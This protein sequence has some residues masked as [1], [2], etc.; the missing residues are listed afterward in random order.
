METMLVLDKFRSG[1]HPSRKPGFYYSS[2]CPEHKSLLLR[3]MCPFVPEVGVG[4]SVRNISLA[5]EAAWLKPLMV[6]HRCAP[7]SRQPL[8]QGQHSMSGVCPVSGDSSRQTHRGDTNPPLC[9]TGQRSYCASPTLGACQ[10][11]AN[12]S[13]ALHQR[14]KLRDISQWRWVSRS[15]KDTQEAFPEILK[16]GYRP[17]RLLLWHPNPAGIRDIFM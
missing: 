11:S 8:A 4:C 3:T 2:L 16:C 7:A 10:P 17:R 12:H 5:P 6:S 9:A 1:C 15:T 14:T 13:C